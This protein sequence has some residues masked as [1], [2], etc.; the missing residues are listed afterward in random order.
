MGFFI[1]STFIAYFDCYMLLNALG[2]LHRS[3]VP[4]DLVSALKK[5][6]PPS[7]VVNQT[8]VEHLFSVGDVVKVRVQSV[9]V[10]TRRLELSMLPMRN[11]NDEEDDYIVE[12]RDPE[13]EEYKSFEDSD[14][15]DENN[16]YDAEDTLLWW[17]GARYVKVKLVFPHPIIVLITCNYIQYGRL[18]IWRRT[19]CRVWMRRPP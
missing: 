17:K 8:D 15:E 7:T 4:R 2:L 10:D 6:V 1:N 12:G 19:K 18:L 14:D 3:Q 9:A 13:G 5:R 11:R 16:H